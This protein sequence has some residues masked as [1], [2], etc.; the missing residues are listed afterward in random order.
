MKF[1]HC[2]LIIFLFS[3]SV[4][5][6]EYDTVTNCQPEELKKSIGL[7]DAS[8]RIPFSSKGDVIIIKLPDD[9][10]AHVTISEA[11][12]KSRFSEELAKIIDASKATVSAAEVHKN[13]G[14]FPCVRH[15]QKYDQSRIT[16]V[17]LDKNNDKNQKTFIAGPAEHVYFS[18][19]M[20][21][22]NARQLTYD[23]KSNTA[24]EKAVPPSFYVGIN[25]KIGD[26]Y[27]TFDNTI[28]P[29]D[30]LSIKLLFKVAAPSESFGVGLGFD[31]GPIVIFAAR[32]KTKNDSSITGVAPNGIYSNIW[33]ASFDIEKG[34]GWLSGK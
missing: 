26:V 22:S 32:I 19:D 17:V 6:A 14:E 4:F 5:G 2:L 21:L 8:E 24:S 25:Y 10:D 30:N 11:K 27:T 23:A 33:G 29:L 1:T 7:D 18:A 15:L 28:N 3:S 13:N 31:V 12:R 20:P 34:I 16:I 9:V